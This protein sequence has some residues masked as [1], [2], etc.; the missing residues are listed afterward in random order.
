[1]RSI[2]RVLVVQPYGIGDALFTTPLLRALRTLPTVE[3]VDLLLG[4]RTEAVFRNNPHV[5][6]IYSIDKDQWHAAGK[7]RA[8]KELLALFR[9]FDGPYD[10]LIDCSLQREYGFYGQFLLRIPRRIGFGYKNRGIFLT[11]R[12]PLPD[13][14]EGAHVIDFYCDLGKLIGLEIKERFLEFYLTEKEMEEGRRRGEYLVVA[15][16]GGESWGK[17]A[18]FKRW[19]ISHFK[20]MLSLLKDRVDFQEVLVIGSRAERELGEALTEGSEIP[21]E[22][23]CGKLSLG[24]CAALLEGAALFLANDGGLVHLAHAL[25]T[26]LVALYGPVDPKVYGPY[27]ASPRAVS[28]VKENLPCQPCYFR[29]RYNSLCPDRECLT[30][31]EPR[32]V[33]E[34]LDRRNFWSLSLTSLRGGE[35]DQAISKSGL[36]RPR[37]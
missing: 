2:R 29:F 14:F 12:L 15:P 10:L 22:N 37:Q 32:E 13:G 21:T 4:S 3:R 7:R 28:V 17:D 6:R 23:L 34:K 16:G 36:L 9:S 19:P 11:D 24:A 18:F 25:H 5:D 27:P 35:A 26:P 1:M 30:A 8:L 31:L 33:L 20:E